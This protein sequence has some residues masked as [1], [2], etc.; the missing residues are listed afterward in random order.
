MSYP[1]IIALTALTMVAFAGNSLLCRAALADASIDAASFAA[2]RLVSGAAMLW[3]VVRFGRAGRASGGGNWPSAAALFAYAAGF[4][5]AYMNLT[6]ATRPP[7]CNP[8]SRSPFQ[9]P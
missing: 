5:F 7:V 8:T 2:V 1:Q 9:I 6:A 3:L 4:S